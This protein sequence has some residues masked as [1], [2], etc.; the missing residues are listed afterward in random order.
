[1]EQHINPPRRTVDA[2]SV[3]WYGV[4]ATNALG[5][6]PTNARATVD[7]V[8]RVVASDV[9]KH[10]CREF[11]DELVYNLAS[12]VFEKPYHKRARK[13]P[14]YLCDQAGYPICLV[15]NYKDCQCGEL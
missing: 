15:C 8:R 14:C 13:V 3:L 7:F 5:K 9:A 6:L 10:V 11:L 2:L 12:S 4:K 1:M